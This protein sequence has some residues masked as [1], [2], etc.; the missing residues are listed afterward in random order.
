MKKIAIFQSSYIPWK[1]TFD[2]MNKVDIFVFFEDV[3]FTK[4]NWRTR[5]KIKTTGGSKWLTVPVKND[6]L[7]DKKIYEV[8]I[9]Q[10]EDWQ[11]NH[12]NAIANS[13]AKAKFFKEYKYLLDEIYLQKKWTNLSEFNIFTNKLIAKTLG[14][15][16][17]FANSKDLA[18]TSSKTDKVV[19]I[20][21]A[22]N[23]NYLLNG[24]TAK[25]YTEEDKLLAAAIEVEYMDY[26]KYPEYTQL[27]G[28]F[29][30]NVT[31]LDVIF[32][33]GPEA[34]LKIFT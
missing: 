34:P 30:H 23:A 11:I 3:Q 19:D 4:K 8:E 33:C 5:N 15:K 20:C 22:F 16:V 1:G 13:Y 10:E 12:Y 21:K 28:E 25:E 27:N 18:I 17:E 32:N 14:I 31:I 9:S 7:L 24:P 26:T 29:E 2:I 6:N